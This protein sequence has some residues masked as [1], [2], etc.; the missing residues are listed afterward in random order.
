LSAKSSIY[1]FPCFVQSP[2]MRQAIRFVLKQIETR[3]PEDFKRIQR[4]VI[5]FADRSSTSNWKKQT[6]ARFSNFSGTGIIE[7]S[8]KIRP[9][10]LKLAVAHELGHTCERPRDYR[11]RRQG[12]SNWIREFIADDYSYKWGFGRIILPFVGSA[13]KI[14]SSMLRNS[15]R[16]LS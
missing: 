11:R 14:P 10:Q 12:K 7:F 15:Q 6:M 3:A 9:A 4:R 2:K 13:V 8:E 5:R 16:P 1:G